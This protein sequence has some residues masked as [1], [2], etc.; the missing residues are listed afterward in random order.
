MAMKW[1]S[2]SD[3]VIISTDE[4]GSE[5]ALVCR[6]YYNASNNIPEKQWE[7]LT[8]QT[9]EHENQWEWQTDPVGGSQVEEVK[10]FVRRR[11]V[12]LCHKNRHA[13]KAQGSAL[14]G[15]D[16]QTLSH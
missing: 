7:F 8:D 6:P 1:K 13:V 11:D 14:F 4:S 3:V 2:S 16:H 9:M 10:H 15:F 12:F 5:Y